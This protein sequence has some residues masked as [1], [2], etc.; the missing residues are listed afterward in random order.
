MESL[1]ADIAANSRI[2][3]VLNDAKRRRD[4]TDIDFREAMGETETDL[5]AAERELVVIKRQKKVI[6]DDMDEVLPRYHTVGEAYTETITTSVMAVTSQQKKDGPSHQ[7]T[8][9]QGVI[10]YYG[11]EREDDEGNIQKYCHLTGWLNPKFI[12]CAHIVPKSLAS[13]ELAYLFGVRETMLTEPRNGKP[14]C[15]I[16]RY[17]LIKHC[18]TGPKS[19]HRN[20]LGQWQHC[21]RTRQASSWQRNYMEVPPNQAVNGKSV[22]QRGDK[23]EGY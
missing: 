22:R 21:L 3:E 12:K 6:L 4:M 19:R 15:G 13:D 14:L 23:M 11:A 5:V 9:R 7:K 1:A 2:K 16:V 20:R 10:K 18:R 8:F 17:L